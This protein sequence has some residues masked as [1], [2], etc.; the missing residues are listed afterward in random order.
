MLKE[1][2]ELIENKNKEVENMLVLVAN[3]EKIE[4]G[5]IRLEF[6]ANEI[7]CKHQAESRRLEVAADEVSLKL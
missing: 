2:V 1:L 5:L 6:T 3:L 7:E 4:N